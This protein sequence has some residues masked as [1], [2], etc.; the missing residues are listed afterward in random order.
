MTEAL[1]NPAP[2]PAPEQAPEPDLGPEVS[3]MRL[4]EVLRAGT[5]VQL[6]DIREP[7]EAEIATIAGSELIPLGTLT[8]AL[9]R[10]RHDVPVVLYC[11]SGARSAHALRMLDRLGIEAT[12]L[13]GGIDAY[14]AT[15][16][17][18]LARY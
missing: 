3:A 16:D 9:D 15:V 7:W 14:A 6:I 10:I 8:S 5:D 11:H 13:T 1:V 12:H 2:E 17:P 18:S 4:A